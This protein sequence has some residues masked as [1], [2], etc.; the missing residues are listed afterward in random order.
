MD[1]PSRGQLGAALRYI[2]FLIMGFAIGFS[3][4]N[5]G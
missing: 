4:G 2:G 1:K 5:W 3:V